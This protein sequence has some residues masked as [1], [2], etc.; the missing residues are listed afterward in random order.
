M[1]VIS[2]VQAQAAIMATHLVSSALSPSVRIKADTVMPRTFLSAARQVLTAG[3]LIQAI[4]TVLPV[5]TR[6]TGAMPRF[7]LRVRLLIRRHTIRV[8]PSHIRAIQ[9]AKHVHA[10]RHQGIMTVHLLVQVLITAVTDQVPLPV[11]T[12]VTAALR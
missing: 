7:V 10:K 5:E 3:R 2:S 11:R 6:V 1:R 4:Q 9:R 8:Q 12:M